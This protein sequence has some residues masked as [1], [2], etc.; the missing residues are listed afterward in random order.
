MIGNEEFETAGQEMEAGSDEAAAAR[1]RELLAHLPDQADAR[2]YLGFCLAFGPARDLAAARRETKRALELDSR[3]CAARASA[4]YVAVIEG[5]FNEAKPLVRA[6]LKADP[7]NPVARAVASLL[8]YS[9]GEYKQAEKHARA[10]LECRP[11][12]SY[13]LFHL[14]VALTYL[15]H[16]DE[17]RT[18]EDACRKARPEYPSYL[19]LSC[20]VAYN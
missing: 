6:A 13:C 11:G 3:S 15:A 10:G 4:A 8:H 1:L 16:F 7:E 2:A 18:L 12:N 9:I 19:W 14:C 5:A 20:F 17:A